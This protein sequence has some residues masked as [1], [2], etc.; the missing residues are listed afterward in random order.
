MQQ[1][2]EK[3]T[4]PGVEEP[5]VGAAAV[6]AGGCVM[7]HGRR[8]QAAVL[9]LNRRR[10]RFLP[11]L[12]FRFRWCSLFLPC[13]FILYFLVLLISVCPFSP[14]SL[15]RS[16]SSPSPFGFPP[17][18]SPFSF[19]FFFLPPPLVPLP[20]LIYRASDRGFS[21]WSMG[22][23]SRGGWSGVQLSRLASLGFGSSAGGR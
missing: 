18:S 17:L 8:L 14:L 10:E 7:A 16:F 3:K 13:L 1:M 19:F 23:R 2:Q 6:E 22:N 5:V 15:I 21:L 9:L 11:L 4:V 12:F 20:G